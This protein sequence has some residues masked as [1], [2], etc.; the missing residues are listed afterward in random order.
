MD[1]LEL[2]DLNDIPAMPATYQPTSYA[3]R[4]AWAV[5]WLLTHPDGRAGRMPALLIHMDGEPRA[6]FVGRGV[7]LP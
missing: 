5:D 4:I 1:I 7:T 2:V 6:R 3:R